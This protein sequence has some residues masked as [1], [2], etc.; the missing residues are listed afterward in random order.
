[1]KYISV[2]CLFFLTGC[3]TYKS[4]INNDMIC[5]FDMTIAEGEKKFDVQKYKNLQEL[6]QIDSSNFILKIYKYPGNQGYV[7]DKTD[8]QSKVSKIIRYSINGSI[9]HVYFQPLK[10]GFEIG[11]ETY[12]DSLGNITQVIDHRQADKY[13]ICYKEALLIAEKLKSKKDS[14]LSIDRGRKINSTGDTLYYWDVCIEEPKPDKDE[15][16]LGDAWIY[17]IDA[18]TGKLLR[19]MQLIQG[20]DDTAP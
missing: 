3:I 2:V 11:Q 15:P 13:P 12:Y 5:Q 17:R 1:M 19:K 10:G 20:H 7:V 4:Y 8:K 9:K 18:Q 16:T 6:H 14:I